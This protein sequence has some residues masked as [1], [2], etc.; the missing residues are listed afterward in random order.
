M[1]YPKKQRNRQ[2]QL[3]EMIRMTYEEQLLTHLLDC[4]ISDLEI[5]H[6]LFDDAEKLGKNISD[7]LYKAALDYEQ[8]KYADILIEET[9]KI[10]NSGIA[11]IIRKRID[12]YYK[13]KGSKE[14]HDYLVAY[15]D[16]ME[17]KFNPSINGLDTWYN[18]ILDPYS[19]Q[20]ILDFTDE[21]LVEAIHKEVASRN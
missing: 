11:T 12:D 14:E 8:F 20:E 9:M 1:N 7:I 16:K 2:L 6:D 18:N 19:V 10:I 13:E 4:E 17:E 21:E 3:H 5:L 15:A